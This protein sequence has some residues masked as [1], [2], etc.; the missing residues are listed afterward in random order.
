MCSDK[1]QGL[2]IS[3][4][5]TCK[6][7]LLELAKEEHHGSISVDLVKLGATFG[8]DYHTVKQASEILSTTGLIQYK[9][10]LNNQLT[11]G[12]SANGRLVVET[13]SSIELIPKN[14]G[15]YIEIKGSPGAVINTGMVGGTIQ[16]SS[17][18]EPQHL[19]DEFEVSLATQASA[20]KHDG[21]ALIIAQLT[22][23]SNQPN[24]T[25]EAS[26]FINKTKHHA[27]SP[28]GL[29]FGLSGVRWFDGENIRF[30]PYDTTTGAWYFGHSPISGTTKIDFDNAA[31]LTL[32][33]IPVRGAII[34]RTL[35]IKYM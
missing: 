30:S 20:N 2:R 9:Q 18:L 4:K 29:G 24:A 27:A 35:T 14:T 21:Y 17:P 15:V 33:I 1:S 12:I 6:L 28:I 16:T 8:A 19:K 3:L 13:G 7:L 31:D 5:E 25:K 22:N 11:G 23:N 10:Y 32:R 34:E 26:I